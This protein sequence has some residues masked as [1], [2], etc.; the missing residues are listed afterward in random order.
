MTEMPFRIGDRIL[1]RENPNARNYT[2]LGR[3]EETIQGRGPHRYG[4][5]LDSGR[6]VVA[7]EDQLALK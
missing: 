1:Y 3:V 2:E 4:V 5:M 7:V 6:R